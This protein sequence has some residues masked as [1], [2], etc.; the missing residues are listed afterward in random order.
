LEIGF[1]G[2]GNMGKP[3]A[4]RLI[5]AGHSLKVYDVNAFV[6]R[7]FA[8]LGAEVAA[9]PQEIAME[10]DKIITML[11]KSSVVERVVLGDQGIIHSIKEGTILIEMSSSS[12]LSTKKIGELLSAKG[13]S[14]I[15]APVSGG[16]KGAAEG[17]LSI[18]IGGEADK[19]EKVRPILEV[20][21]RKLVH[22][23][24]L[25]SGHAVKALNNMLCATTLLATSEAMAV[26]VK[27]GVEPDKMLDAI[28][29]SSGKSHSSEYKFPNVLNRKFDVGFTIDLMHKDIGIA[30]EIADAVKI[31]TF[32]GSTV[33][34]FWGLAASQGG[35]QWDHTAIV[36]FVE[37]WAG[38]ELESASHQQ[39][40]SLDDQ[41][42]VK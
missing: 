3:M 21:G 39:E 10:C 34:Q 42:Q 9:T 31:P 14:I 33:Q 36:K 30:M 13:V 22:V 38:L 27:F 28:N 4:E 12:P 15:D 6:L 16:V 1:I 35:G 2:L 7:H 8:E 11:P 19:I 17:T 18:M 26:G 41:K 40:E 5:K 25:G 32:T 24:K 29:N 20:L 37:M 23:G